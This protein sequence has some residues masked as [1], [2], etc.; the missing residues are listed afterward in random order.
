VRVAPRFQLKTIMP[1]RLTDRLN[2]DSIDEFLAAACERYCDGIE[3]AAQARRMGAIYLFGYSAE[4]VMKAAYFRAIGVSNRA[5][6]GRQSHLNAAVTRARQLGVNW[7]NPRN[8]HYVQGWAEL[9]VVIQ[10]NLVKTSQ[11]PPASAYA[12]PTFAHRVREHAT[13]VQ[14]LWNESL[15]YHKNRAYEFELIRMQSSVDW[16]MK[17]LP[18]L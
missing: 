13:I 14:N 17:N 18:R 16:L 5:P 12:D 7:P 11:P 15:R 4:M 2:P 10:M 8:L 6:L 9:L 3:L 1:K